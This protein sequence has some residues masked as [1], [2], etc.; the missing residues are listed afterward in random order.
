MTQ[1]LLKQVGFGI[2]LPTN[3]KFSQAW[4][5][6]QGKTYRIAI[7]WIEKGVPQLI[8]EQT[9]FVN[10][11]GNVKHQP[12]FEKITKKQ[13]ST[14]VGTVIMVFTTDRDGELLKDDNGK[15]VLSNYQIMPWLFSS[16]KYQELAKLHKKWDLSKHD[17]SVECTDAQYMKLVIQP[18]QE[19]IFTKMLTSKQWGE[20]LK[21]EIT[22][23]VEQV[24]NMVA[25][26]VTVDELREALGLTTQTEQFD[27]TTEVDVLD[28]DFGS[29][30]S[31][32]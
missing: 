20:K 13:P 28:V 6:E 22:E 27:P 8:H 30:E 24:K 16:L 14:R 10:G 15:P 3:S 12:G 19:S 25:R 11:L 32:K 18:H 9:H 21:T 2:D 7:A 23:K 5:P 31:E 26:E 4:K 17:L 1:E 29:F